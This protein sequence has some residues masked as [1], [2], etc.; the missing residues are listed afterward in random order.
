MRQGILRDCIG[1]E[2][3]GMGQVAIEDVETHKV[4]LVIYELKRTFK[5]LH[6][7]KGKEVYWECDEVG[8]LAKVEPVKD[9]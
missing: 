6:R 3:A 1:I 2:T 4:E 5:A 7:Y 9:S 8:M